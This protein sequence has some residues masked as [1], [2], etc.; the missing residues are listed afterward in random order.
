MLEPLQVFYYRCS[1]RNYEQIAKIPNSDICMCAENA[2]HS[3]VH[4]LDMKGKLSAS[5]LGMILLGKEP[6]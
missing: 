5:W 6:M 1:R 3:N 2:Y 4:N